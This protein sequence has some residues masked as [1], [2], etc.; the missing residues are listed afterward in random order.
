MLKKRIITSSLLIPVIVGSIFIDWVFGVTVIIFTIAGLYEFFGMLENKGITIYK[1][2]GITIGTAI[3]FSILAR[4]ELTNNWELLFIVLTLITL[5]MMQFQRRQSSGVVVGISTT[6]FGILYVSWFLSFMIRIRFLEGGAGL[7]LSLLLMTKLTD[8]GAYFVGS[9]F[10][11]TPLMRRISPKKSVEGAIGGLIFSII[12]ALISRPL[13]HFSY[14]HLALL[15]L[16]IGIL[17]QAGDLSESLIKRDC[18]LKDSG[19]IFPGMGGILDI[20]DSLLFTAPVFYFYL[21]TA[22]K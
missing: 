2:L 18:Q 5:I 3:P 4:F 14:P 19:N 22:V 6:I 12:G 15:G 10:G 20:T 7:V 9:R 21:S 16:F 8:A 1:Y 11:K 13:L 17:A